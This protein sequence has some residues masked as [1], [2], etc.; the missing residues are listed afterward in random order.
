MNEEQYQQRIKDLEDRL[1]DSINSKHSVHQSE[2]MMARNK[3]V[4]MY[5]KLLEDIEFSKNSLSAIE[6]LIN[7]S[8]HLINKETGIYYEN[9]CYWKKDEDGIKFEVKP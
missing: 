1:R 4:M 5:I 2:I 7:Y 8:R 9:G 6:S 3:I